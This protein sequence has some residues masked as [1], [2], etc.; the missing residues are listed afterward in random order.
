MFGFDDLKKTK[1]LF[2]YNSQQRFSLTFSRVD[3]EALAQREFYKNATF[4]FFYQ[5][6][7]AQQLSRKGFYTFV[8]LLL[9][10]ESQKNDSSVFFVS[11]LPLRIYFFIKSLK[12]L[13]SKQ[14]KFFIV[15]ENSRKITF[16]I[17]IMCKPYLIQF[18]SNVYVACLPNLGCEQQRIL[19]ANV[20]QGAKLAKLFVLHIAY[21]FCYFQYSFSSST[22]SSITIN[23]SDLAQQHFKYYLFCFYL[24]LIVNK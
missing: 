23:L 2:I 10:S 20:R 14:P 5:F 17:S 19:L 13:T 6:T 7:I 8:F 24:H 22:S 4:N 15:T 18:T 12:L 11:V 1:Y 9:P 3:S 16:L 21:R